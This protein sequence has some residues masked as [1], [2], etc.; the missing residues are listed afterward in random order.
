[1]IR[2]IPSLSSERQ[3][4]GTIEGLLYEIKGN[5][6]VPNYTGFL[7][8]SANKESLAAFLSEYIC[9]NGQEVLSRDT[10]I[11]LAGGFADG[12]VVKVVHGEGVSCLEE[13]ESTQKEVDT[14]LLLHS[15]V[16]SR[17]HS[18]IIVRCDD[19]DVLVL[20]LYYSSKGMLANEV[21]MHAGHSYKIFTKERYI[22][23]HQ[24]SSKLGNSICHYLPAMHALSGCD[25]TTALHR[26]G[27]R[28]AYSALAKNADAL[29]GLTKFEDK[30]TFLESSQT[31]AL[32]LHGKKFKHCSSLNE[33]RFIL[34]MTTDKAA[35]L[36]PP[37][38]DAYEQH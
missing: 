33:L 2:N 31:F 12:E 27:K 34:A 6:D 9:E 22:P 20:L 21:Y 19:T 36:L 5:I 8:F 15:I 14:R 25:T 4:R 1:M 26:L 18:R 17:D 7:K 16:L 11:V 38:E 28:T 13:L 10:S 37:T 30:D 3:R 23:I 24:I 29:H 32:L 35:P